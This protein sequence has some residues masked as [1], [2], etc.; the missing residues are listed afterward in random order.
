MF[1]NF[2]PPPPHSHPPPAPSFLKKY[3]VPSSARFVLLRGMGSDLF[4]KA[5]IG[6]NTFN[7]RLY[8]KRGYK[9]ALDTLSLWVEKM[10]ERQRN[11]EVV[12]SQEIQDMVFVAKTLYEM[13][14]AEHEDRLKIKQKQKAHFKKMH[15][16]R[17]KAV[18]KRR[19]EKAA[20]ILAEGKKSEIK[21]LEVEREAHLKAMDLSKDVFG[22][23][24]NEINDRFILAKTMSGIPLNK[25]FE[26][27]EA[28]L[29]AEHPSPPDTTE[30]ALEGMDMGSEVSGE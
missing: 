5:P 18:E 23:M 22:E 14:D 15:E 2:H 1:V 12:N 9:L 24:A 3:S 11:G 28:E 13:S 17:D 19:A 26:D 21:K 8:A 20:K 7:I 30:E 16:A 27:F 10:A 6:K 25:K 29:E 4:S